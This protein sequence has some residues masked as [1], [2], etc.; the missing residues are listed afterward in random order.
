MAGYFKNM[1]DLLAALRRIEG[2]ISGL[3]PMVGG[4]PTAST[5]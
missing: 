3:Q 2:Q 5:F 4:T 1:E